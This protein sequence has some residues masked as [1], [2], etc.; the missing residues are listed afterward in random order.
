M[1]PRDLLLLDEPTNHLDLDAVLWLE[2]WLL[3]YP[4]TLL[5]IS[6]DREFLDDVTTHTLHLHE[7]S[8]QA[9]HRRLH[10]VRAPA[11]RAAAPAADRPREGAGRARAPAELH[12]PLQGQGQQG[13]A[14]AVAHQ[15]PGEAGRHR[16]G[17]RRARAAHR[18][19]G[20]AEAAA[21]ADAP[22]PRR[23]PATGA[24]SRRILHDVGF[25][26]EA[27]DRVGLLGPNGAGKS[28]LVK[29]LV[30]ELPLLAGERSAHP[31]LRIG[32]FAQHT[33]ESL[34]AGRRPIEHLRE[35]APGAGDAAVPRLPRQVEFP[36]RPRVR[37]RSTASPAARRARLALALI[38]YAQAERAAAR[39][40]DQPP[41]PRH[42][43]SAGRGAERFRRRDRAG[44]AR[45]P[46]DRPGLRHVLARGRRQGRAF[47]GDLDEYA[48]WLRSR[49]QRA[50]GKAARPK[51]AAPPPAPRAGAERRPRRRSTRTRWRRPKRAWR[52]WRRRSR[53]STTELADPALYADGGGGR[54]SSAAAQAQLRGELE[55]CRSRV[56]GA[57]RRC[58]TAPL[59]RRRGSHPPRFHDARAPAMPIY[60]FECTACGHTFD[61]L[62]RLSDPDPTDVPRCGADAVQPP[63]DRAVVPPVRRRLVRDRLQ[64]G[65]RQE[66][67]PGR[68]AAAARPASEI[69]PADSKPAEKKA[70]PARP[71]PKPD[72]EAG[73]RSRFAGPA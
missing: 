33:V 43:R 17:A 16:G 57:V 53:T 50:G 71:S 47:D 19:P 15:A 32:Y 73:R 34:H 22:E 62:Q 30:G 59:I 45:P 51:A 66:A 28:T 11:R 56:A 67:Q 12:R 29:T 20:A 2:Q 5:V 58:L 24:T 68:G 52:S 65:R 9:L 54:A 8:A 46:P 41:R 60:A 37:D 21:L 39:R 64:E 70:E 63:A 40:T 61:R 1:T 72:A 48:A 38:A 49:R 69:K 14:G 23:L 7:G 55:R 18:V 6:H 25:G 44:L 10:R 26:L 4:G 42:A 13:Q 3:K 35:I 27:G 31:D 36:R